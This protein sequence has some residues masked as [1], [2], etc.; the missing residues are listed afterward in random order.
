MYNVVSYRLEMNTFNRLFTVIHKSIYSVVIALI[1]FIM[2]GSVVSAQ[3]DEQGCLDDNGTWDESSMTCEID[4]APANINDGSDNSSG[5]DLDILRSGENCE[6]DGGE[7]TKDNCSIV[8]ILIV[9]IN[10]LSAVAGLA[11]IA[12]VIIA[13]YQYMTAQDNSSQISA[14]RNRIIWAITAMA[15]FIFTYALLNFLVPGGVL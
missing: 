1:V 15:L 9:G 14:A 12:S 6:G 8:G 7:L 11:I 4:A 5:S 3:S 2:V 13:G 10:F